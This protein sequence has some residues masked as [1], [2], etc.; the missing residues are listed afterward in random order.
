MPGLKL[1]GFITRLKA[2]KDLNNQNLSDLKLKSREKFHGFFCT[3]NQ[4]LISDS[5]M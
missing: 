5:N 3:S 1:L 2:I 4:F